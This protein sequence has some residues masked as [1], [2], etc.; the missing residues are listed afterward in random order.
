MVGWQPSLQIAVALNIWLE[1]N[2]A[3]NANQL[4]SFQSNSR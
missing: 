4:S 3:E 2:Q 1:R